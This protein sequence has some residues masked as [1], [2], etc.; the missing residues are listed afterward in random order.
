M[1]VLLFGS[2][3]SKCRMRFAVLINIDIRHEPVLLGAF[4][5][6][7]SRKLRPEMLAFRA[8]NRRRHENK[9]ITFLGE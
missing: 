9:M 8:N 2:P 7:S 4:I 6:R 1:F 5:A 3:H